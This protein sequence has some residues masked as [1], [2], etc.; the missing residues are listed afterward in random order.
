MYSGWQVNVHSS[1]RRDC[2]HG[3]DRFL[4]VGPPI[5]RSTLDIIINA[6]REEGT[7][8]NNR[9]SSGRGNLRF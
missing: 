5:C 9:H 2:N 8:A 1:P 7:I 3:A 6:H 4:C